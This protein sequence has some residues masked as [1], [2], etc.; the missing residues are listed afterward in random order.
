MAK[1]RASWAMQLNMWQNDAHN[2][3]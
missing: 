1:K 2:C 3:H